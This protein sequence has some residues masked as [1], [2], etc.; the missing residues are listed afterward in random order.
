MDEDLGHDVKEFNPDDHESV[1][2]IVRFIVEKLKGDGKKKGDGTQFSLF[3]G[4]KGEDYKKIMDT[5]D[6]KNMDS[7][8]IEEKLTENDNLI[9]RENP[10]M[11]VAPVPHRA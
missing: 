7:Y 9:L 2:G 6:V 1:K 4:K 8:E 3:G 11:M 10:R 5:E